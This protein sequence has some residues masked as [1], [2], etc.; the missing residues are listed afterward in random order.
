MTLPL[1]NHPKLIGRFHPD[2]PNDIQVLVH[3]GGPRISSVSPELIWVTVISERNSIFRGR[4]L[5]A[6]HNLKSVSQYDEISF[7]VPDGSPH[8]VLV[9]R[10]SVV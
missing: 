8:P 1:Q 3:D 6:P 2:Y 4:I 9:D 7:L 10:K 5:N